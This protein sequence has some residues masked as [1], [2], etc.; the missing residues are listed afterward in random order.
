MKTR[1][2]NKNALSISRSDV[3]SYAVVD[4]LMKSETQIRQC[5]TQRGVH[6][7]TRMVLVL[8]GSVE[9]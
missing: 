5:V 8:Q 1:T 4:L 9:L 3:V 2:S 7:N 6:A